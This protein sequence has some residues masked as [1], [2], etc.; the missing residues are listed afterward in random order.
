MIGVV[1]FATTIAI[2][3][4][5]FVAGVVPLWLAAVILLADGLFTYMLITTLEKNAS[6]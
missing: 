4:G 5:L 1:S 3:L 2:V 6:G